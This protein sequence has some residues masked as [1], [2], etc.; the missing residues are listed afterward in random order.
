MCVCVCV[1]VCL[2]A[3][4]E[5]LHIRRIGICHVIYHVKSMGIWEF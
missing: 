5:T 2:I 4:H 3:I 1:C